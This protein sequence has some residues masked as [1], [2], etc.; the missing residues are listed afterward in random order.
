MKKTRRIYPC[1]RTRPRTAEIV[2]G[3]HP[4]VRDR[5]SSDCSADD[6][7]LAGGAAWVWRACYLR[8][9]SCSSICRDRRHFC[10]ASGADADSHTAGA[11]FRHAGAAPIQ[12][13]SAGATSDVAPSE[14]ACVLVRSSDD[15]AY[16][17]RDEFCDARNWWAGAGGSDCDFFN[18]FSFHADKG[19]LAHSPTGNR[20]ASAMDDP[21]VF[22]RDC[23]GDDSA[24][25]G[26]VFRDEQTDGSDASTILRL[27]VLARLRAA[28]DFDGV[29]AANRRIE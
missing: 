10:A 13:R 27:G 26:T 2:G 3:D 16:C 8:E 14:R 21:L 19:V 6:G 11:A 5:S 23:G 12:C 4:A 20:D 24:D 25:R 18:V 15:R 17:V 1:E 7:A 28:F 22:Y 9:P 29:L